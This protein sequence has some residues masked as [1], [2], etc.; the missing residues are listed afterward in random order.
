ML[1]VLALLVYALVLVGIV[2]CVAT[3]ISARSALAEPVHW[4]TF[5]LTQL[6]CY[7][8]RYGERCDPIGTWTADDRGLVLHDV[9]LDD[10]GLDRQDVPTGPQRAGYR[11]WDADETGV[12]DSVYDPSTVDDAWTGWAVCAPILLALGVMLAAKWGDLDRLW[13]YRQRRRAQASVRPS[14]PGP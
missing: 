13:Q 6:S 11:D 9:L 14:A 2:S 3:A 8:T 4:G 5:R 1:T 10:G 12:P 7:Q